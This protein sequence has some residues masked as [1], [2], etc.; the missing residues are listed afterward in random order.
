MGRWWRLWWGIEAAVADER[1]RLLDMRVQARAFLKV[2]D[3]RDGRDLRKRELALGL[4]GDSS[5]AIHAPDACASYARRARK[6]L[7]GN[8]ASVLTHAGRGANIRVI[9]PGMGSARR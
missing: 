3:R 4:G 1:V 2:A 9:T 7:Y 5:R 8:A 6:A